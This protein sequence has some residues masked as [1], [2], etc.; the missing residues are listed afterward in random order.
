M[1]TFVAF[2]ER[3][4]NAP[5]HQFL[6]LLLRH[7]SLELHNLTPSRAQHIVTFVTLCEAYLVID[8]QQEGDEHSAYINGTGPPFRYFIGPTS[9][10]DI[11][12]RHGHDNGGILIES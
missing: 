10:N 5:S 9:F 8:P 3:G 12:S 4:F 1:V 2:Y 11:E 7:Y 6:C